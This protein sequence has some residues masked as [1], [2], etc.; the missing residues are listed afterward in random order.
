MTYNSYT[1]LEEP[2]SPGH[3]AWLMRL[4][5]DLLNSWCYINGGDQLKARLR[6]VRVEENSAPKS[7]QAKLNHRDFTFTS[8][9]LG[10]VS[11]CCLIKTY[12]FLHILVEI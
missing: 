6:T 9:S 4:F 12:F 10:R 1:R 8:V 2:N 5:L 3:I 7:I 11:P